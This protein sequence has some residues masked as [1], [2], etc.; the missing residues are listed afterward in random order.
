LQQYVCGTECTAVA[1]WFLS[2]RSTRKLIY[3][4]CIA[5][6]KLAACPVEPGGDVIIEDQF[7]GIA[8]AFA[9]GGLLA[10]DAGT[11]LYDILSDI[12][13]LVPQG[14]YQYPIQATDQAG[15]GTSQL[16]HPV[17]ITIPD[18]K[19]RSAITYFTGMF[20]VSMLTALL[21][22]VSLALESTTLF[23]SC[24]AL[25]TARDPDSNLTQILVR[26]P[27]VSQTIESLPDSSG[28][29]LAKAWLSASADI[30]AMG[31]SLGR[32]EGAK[33][34]NNKQWVIAQL[35]TAQ[36]FE[37]NLN[38]DLRLTKSL[39][40]AFVQDL[41]SQGLQVSPASLAAA[42]SQILA[43]GLPPFE[44]NVLAELGF[45]AQSISSLGPAAAAALIGFLPTD[46]QNTLI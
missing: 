9:K 46:W 44:Q 3:V 20:P 40:A 7:K 42:Q 23:F 36:G 14:L 13:K 39:M 34:A 12:T 35:Q 43:T 33:A 17:Q 24:A 22:P 4:N 8:A 18:Y 32:Y 15:G 37:Q 1:V 41:Q 25:D 28:K 5:K 45:T 2:S 26:Q 19:G 30:K 31:M 21:T 10:F 16:F 27:I 11:E 6:S 38:A 29:R